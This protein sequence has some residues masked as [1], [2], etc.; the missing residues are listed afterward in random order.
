VISFKAWTT[1]RLQQIIT[2]HIYFEIYSVKMGQEAYFRQPA[3]NFSITELAS[4]W[5]F[6]P[7]LAEPNLAWGALIG[8]N[9]FFPNICQIIVL[10]ASFKGATTMEPTSNNQQDLINQFTAMTVRAN[11][12]EEIQLLQTE[13]TDKDWN[14]CLALRVVTPRPVVSPISRSH[15]TGAGEHLIFK[16]S[17]DLQRVYLWQ[18]FPQCLHVTK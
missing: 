16:A 5:P 9:L 4:I 1:E 14:C 6:F 17:P 15:Y 7:P 11:S 12:R 8:L 18:N 3:W 2:Q 10:S 13:I